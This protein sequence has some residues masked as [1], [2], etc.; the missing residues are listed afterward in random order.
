MHRPDSPSESLDERRPRARFRV[1]RR[2]DGHRQRP[3]D[4]QF[5][6]VVCD[7]EIFGRIVR[8]VD[9]VADI[10]RRGECLEAVQEAGRDVEVTKVGVVQ[11]KCLLLAERGR[12]A[13]D[14]DQHVVHR[15]VGTAHELRLAATRAAVHS[16]DHA[17]TGAGLRI[18]LK[19][20]ST[21]WLAHCCVEDLRVERS[22]EQSAVVAERLRNEDQDIGKF[23]GFD[24]HDSI[25]P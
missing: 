15:T 25:L 7:A 9:A 17:F 18:L 23:G 3:R 16:S 4:R 24:A 13:T 11:A 10:S 5:G 14:V 20:R 21:A 19:R 2:H 1:A 8:S 22:S 12:V 6:V